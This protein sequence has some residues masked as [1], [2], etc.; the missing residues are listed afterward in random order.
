MKP[1]PHRVQYLFI[2]LFIACIFIL[3][4]ITP[5]G[6]AAWLFYLLPILLISKTAKRNHIFVVTTICTVLMFIGLMF[7]PPGVEFHYG[8]I[9]CLMGTAVFWLTATF[10]LNH[11][12]VKES[13]RES[14]SLFRSLAE[15]AAD[16]IYLIQDG[17]FRYVNP[18]FTEIFGYTAVELLGRLGP[19]DLTHPD[20]WPSAQKYIRE[21]MVG[22]VKFVHYSFRGVTKQQ[23]LVDI[24]VYGS[25]TVYHGHPAIIGTLLDVTERKA[26]ETQLRR[27]EARFSTIFRTSPIGIGI[28]RLSDGRF[29]DVNDAFLS[30]HGYRRDEVLGYTSSE[31]RLWAYPEERE[32]MMKKLREQGSVRNFESKF[33][34]KTG[35]VG[36]LL[37][38]AELIELA[39]VPYLLG[40]VSDIAKLKRTENLIRIRLRLSGLAQ[41]SSL[42]GLMQAALDDAER[43]TNSTIGFFHFVDADQEHISL[44]A[45]STNTL[46][47][48]C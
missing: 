48:M 36:D 13:L 15:K 16:G 18:R 47:T 12:K 38:S 17:I 21:R 4:I 24:E 10:Y 40:M 6:F 41:Q 27:S 30:I 2:A 46:Q 20:D 3:D 37:I 7:S 45:W 11:L 39:G 1:T 9:N 28:S 34:K 33:Q 25:A 23:G 29:I 19:K 35:E 43:M 14:E 22:D 31:L 26:S 42:D 8:L 5:V 32:L 44:Q